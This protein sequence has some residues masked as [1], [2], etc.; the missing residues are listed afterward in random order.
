[1]AMVVYRKRPR[2]DE[3]E[4]SAVVIQR[5]FRNYRFR[6][7]LSNLAVM[8]QARSNA[9]AGVIPGYSRRSG[10]YGRFTGPG[11]S[12]ELKFFDTGISFNAD[13]TAEIPATGQ[14]ALIPQDDTQSGRD[15]NKAVIK[16]ITM[17]GIA[18]LV[19]GAAA[20]ATDVLYFYLIQDTQ[21]N[22]AA[23]T[24]ADANS[25]IFTGA[26]LST[27][28]HTIANSYRFRV[29]KKWVITFNTGAGVATAFN[30][31]VRTWSFN[32]KCNIPIFYD[33]SATTGAL[34]TIRSNNLFLVAG[35]AGNTDD[36]IAVQGTCRLRFS[37]D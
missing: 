5:A 37:D 29:L 31:Y 19:P 28:N 35:T 16:S 30:Q 32:K 7:G 14:L 36:V 27:A 24:V 4:R 11:Y 18:N 26:N 25:G 23:A 3:R 8:R 33:A 34:T 13:A 21:A 20:S 15:G 12:R 1:M 17:H 2:V 10:Y 9:M 22:G 6:K